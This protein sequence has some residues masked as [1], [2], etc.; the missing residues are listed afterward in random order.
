MTLNEKV[1]EL[2]AIT[3]ALSTDE[4]KSRLNAWKASQ[5]KEEVVEE[6]KPSK[7][8]KDGSLNV[9]SFS[10]ETRGAA[11]KVNEKKTE[12]APITGANVA[13]TPVIAPDTASTL[14]NGSLESSDSN[15][16]QSIINNELV[17]RG[18]DF[19]F[20]SKD[21]QH[22]VLREVL[23]KVGINSQARYHQK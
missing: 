12:A 6:V 13:A 19:V 15:V 14:E 22:K 9:D 16:I 8:N 4:I 3:P 20:G 10:E 11:E 7:F 18:K 1:E 17:A 2:R 23:N 21:Y 5:P